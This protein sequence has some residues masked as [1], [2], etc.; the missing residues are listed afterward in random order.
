MYILT[1]LQ[2]VKYYMLSLLYTHPVYQLNI[3]RLGQSEERKV[4]CRIHCT[5]SYLF[6]ILFLFKLLK[7]L[8][9]H[10]KKSFLNLKEQQDKVLATSICY[11]YLLYLMGGENDIIIFIF[12]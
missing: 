3:Q 10:L 6:A 5:G 7:L 8:E 4:Y 9:N 1:S 12:I 11:A 2:F